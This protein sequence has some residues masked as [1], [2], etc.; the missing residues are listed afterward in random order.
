MKLHVRVLKPDAQNVLSE[1]KKSGLMDYAYKAFNSGNYVFI[2]VNGK[3]SRNDLETVKIEGRK[4][5]EGRYPS[6]HRGSYDLIGEIAVIHGKGRALRNGLAENI[7]AEKR[8]IRSVYLDEGISGTSRLRN[9]KLISGEENLTTRYRE[10]GIVLEIDLS[11]AYFS[12]RLATE[13]MRVARA[14]RD[15]EKIVDMFAGVGPFSILIARLHDADITALD[16]NADAIAL[17]KRN[18]AINRLKGRINPVEADA[19]EYIRGVTGS[20]RIIMNLPHTAS[21][22][23]GDASAALRT[24]GTIHY[25]EIC[26]IELIEKRMEEFAEHD[27]KVTGKREVHGYSK[28]DRMYALDLTKIL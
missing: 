18:I 15:G 3:F 20:D 5:P 7:I 23:V 25:Y 14:V 11:K 17:M 16:V 28:N 8:N 12:P 9:L 6:K 1:L 4:N 10:N 21:S 27:L 13:R 19:G 24:G 2:P 26:S 22:F